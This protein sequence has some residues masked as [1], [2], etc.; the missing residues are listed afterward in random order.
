M[1]R[2]IIPAGVV[3]ILV[4]LAALGLL[5]AANSG[6]APSNELEQGAGQVEETPEDPQSTEEQGAAREEPEQEATVPEGE[7]T[8][9]EDQEAQDGQATPQAPG[10]REASIQITGNAAYYCS[11]GVIGEAQTIE[12][13]TPNTYRVDVSTGGTSLDTVMA[14][15]Q[16]ISPGTLGVRILYDGE[17]VARD[18]TTARLGTISVVWNPLE[19]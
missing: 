5:L 2:W 17:V 7:L 8:T 15:C 19:Q 16:K 13:R 3:G 1:P 11:A 9:P 10:P 6:G 12:G 18:E 14:A 4:S